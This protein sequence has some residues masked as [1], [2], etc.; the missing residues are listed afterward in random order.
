MAL[1]G[2]GDSGSVLIGDMVFLPASHTCLW[3]PANFPH[4]A[5]YAPRALTK[6]LCDA[7]HP[8]WPGAACTLVQR[9]PLHDRLPHERGAKEQYA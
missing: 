1:V 9:R 8:T 7:R 4:G 3:G 6:V 5:P 2:T